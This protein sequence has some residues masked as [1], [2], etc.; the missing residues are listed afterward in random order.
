MTSRAFGLSKVDVH[1][2]NTSKYKS[3]REVRPTSSTSVNF[4][5]ISCMCSGKEDELFTP[6]VFSRVPSSKAYFRIKEM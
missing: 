4:Q 2:E 1:L 3:R 6:S 5:F